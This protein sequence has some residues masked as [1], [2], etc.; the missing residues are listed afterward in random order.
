M[1]KNSNHT[2]YLN[3]IF[4]E[5]HVDRREDLKNQLQDMQVS[6][7]MRGLLNG[8]LP[9]DRWEDLRQRLQGIYRRATGEQLAVLFVE[10]RHD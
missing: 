2:Q 5:A 6:L 3:R 7:A 1:T 9:P 10:V 8:Y 4:R